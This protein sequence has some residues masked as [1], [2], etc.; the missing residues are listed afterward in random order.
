MTREK[1]RKMADDSRHLPR[2]QNANKPILKYRY[3][4]QSW[5]VF[6]L[7]Y[8][9]LCTFDFATFLS[10]SFFSLAEI[11]VIKKHASFNLKYLSVFYCPSSNTSVICIFVCICMYVMLVHCAVQLQKA[12]GQTATFG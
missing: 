9:A 2:R 5:N 11:I 7:C 8:V 3:V 4:S 6:V 12:R 1:F 10:Y